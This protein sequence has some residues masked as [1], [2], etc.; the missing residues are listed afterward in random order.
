M[1][2]SETFEACAR[3]AAG[4]FFLKKYSENDICYYEFYIF[5]SKTQLLST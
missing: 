4:A 5:V 1:M 3:L 2:L